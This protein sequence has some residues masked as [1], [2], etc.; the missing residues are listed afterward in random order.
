VDPRLRDETVL[1]ACYIDL[2]FW[3]VLVVITCLIVLL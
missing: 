2:F 1:L 3:G